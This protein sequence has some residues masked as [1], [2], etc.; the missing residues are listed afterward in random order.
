M[1]WARIIVC[2]WT[3]SSCTIGLSR[4]S[5]TLG[6][7]LMDDDLVVRLPGLQGGLAANCYKLVSLDTAAPRVVSNHYQPA[8]E[9]S[10]AEPQLVLREKPAGLVGDVQLFVRSE[11]DTA[12]ERACR[13]HG[14]VPIE[15]PYVIGFGV[16]VETAA[17][18]GDGGKV[19]RRQEREYELHKLGRQKYDRALGFP[20]G[21]I[22][23][24]CRRDMS[25]LE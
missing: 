22:F 7:K 2:K 24:S 5:F 6:L 17:R 9:I 11:K 19:E 14:T 12:K 1:R 25:A 4:C 18:Y 3:A 23:M 13:E 10:V 21:G 20:R 16:L 8:N 15:V